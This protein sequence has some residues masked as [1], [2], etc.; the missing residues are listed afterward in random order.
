M[1]L[2]LHQ[3]SYSYPA[4]GRLFADLNGEWTPGTLNALTGPSGSGKSTLLD[5]LG[6]LQRPDEGSVRLTST[7]GDVLA[8]ERHRRACSWVLQS[9]I[10]FGRRSVIDNVVISAAIAGGQS[11]AS[12]REAIEVLARLNLAGREE[13]VVD[14]LS[15]G[16]Q[17]RV[18]IAR[19]LMAPAGIL[20]ADEP[21]GNLDAG[22][23]A[24]VVEGL[25]VAADAGKTVIVATHDDAVV[26]ACDSVLD[27]AG[28][29]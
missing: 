5:L 8:P 18:T 10:L 9:N 4:S 19:C 6:A 12:R 24:L 16:E 11:R 17:Q 3:V 13:R 15:G 20:L 28:A 1:R 26:A 22:N 25:R 7:L 2:I 29:P 23:T 14:T 27:L 21:T